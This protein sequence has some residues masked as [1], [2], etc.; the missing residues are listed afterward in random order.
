MLIFGTAGLRAKL[1]RLLGRR[2]LYRCGKPGGGRQARA[3][4]R[5]G[6]RAEDHGA[7]SSA[8][9]LAGGVAT[10]V[11]NIPLLIKIELLGVSL[12]GDRKMR[13]TSRR[14][15]RFRVDIA[16]LQELWRHGRLKPDHLK[17]GQVK[18]DAINRVFA[19]LKSGAPVRDLISVG[20]V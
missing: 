14:G 15:N 8:M 13:G 1:Q 10:I 7:Q 9:P 6:D 4:L 18:L 20:V 19:M 17:S 16:R 12:L 3:M 11:A 5:Q 2:Q